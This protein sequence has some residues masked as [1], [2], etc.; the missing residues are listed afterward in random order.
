MNKILI[1][2]IY[3]INTYP[4]NK[5]SSQDLPNEFSIAYSC[6]YSLYYYINLLLEQYKNDYNYI[7]SSSLIAS[8][9]ILIN[10][11]IMK[12]IKI[13]FYNQHKL[14]VIC[15][16]ISSKLLDDECYSNDVWAS[17]LHIPIKELN[18]MEYTILKILKHELYMSKELYDTTLKIL[19]YIPLQRAI[20]EIK[21]ISENNIL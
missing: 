13:P 1:A 19:M 2:L 11:L 20:N 8:T 7:D 18:K 5:L 4:F 3:Y 10:K 12:G 16:I 17:I 15:I 6:S 14:I 21:N 9:F